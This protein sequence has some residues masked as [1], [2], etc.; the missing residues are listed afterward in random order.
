MEARIGATTNIVD[1]Y[2]NYL[3]RKLHDRP[4]A[5]VIQTVRG[6]GYMIPLAMETEARLSAAD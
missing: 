2:V 6:S 1:V 4:P 3:R 5:S